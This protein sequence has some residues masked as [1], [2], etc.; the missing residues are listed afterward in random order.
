MEKVYYSHLDETYTDKFVI[1]NILS[2]GL[3]F[4]ETK[5]IET[6]RSVQKLEIKYDTF[7]QEIM[8]YGVVSYTVYLD[9]RQVHYCGRKGEIFIEKF[10]TS[11]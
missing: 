8:K 7:I 4:D 9:G 1:P 6:L 2:V 11:F 10:P 5:V 3:C